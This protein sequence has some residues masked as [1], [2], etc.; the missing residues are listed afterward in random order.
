MGRLGACSR[1]HQV[2]PQAAGCR[3]LLTGQAPPPLLQL[4]SGGTITVKVAIKQVQVFDGSREGRHQEATLSCPEL[5]AELRGAL[6]A[7]QDV[8]PGE[9]A[10]LGAMVEALL[11]FARAVRGG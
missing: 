11:G 10:R 6:A 2:V 3:Q 8:E 5:D 9:A 1:S 7:G 4:P